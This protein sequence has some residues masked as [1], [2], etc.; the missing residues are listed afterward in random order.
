MSIHRYSWQKR[1]N[2]RASLVIIGAV[3]WVIGN[4]V[5]AVM[6]NNPV[7]T[8]YSVELCLLYPY[9]ESLLEFQIM[10]VTA[11]GEILM[12]VGALMNNNGVGRT[13][14]S[15]RKEGNIKIIT[16]G[17][18]A[19]LYLLIVF[20]A[21]LAVKTFAMVGFVGEA[22]VG[23]ILLIQGLALRKKVLEDTKQGQTHYKA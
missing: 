4:F 21:P 9:T 8:C 19:G 15:Y 13:L 5:I 6:R 3:L 16:G 22:V 23:V 14:E 12:L 2:L 7:W 18:F 17:V 1:R 20:G 11:V 10:L